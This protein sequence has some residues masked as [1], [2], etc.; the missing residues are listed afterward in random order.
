M[1]LPQVKPITLELLQII[2]QTENDELANVMQKIVFTYSE[3]IA[4]IA[5]EICQHLA[6]TFSM[7]LDTD[8]G[9]DEKAIAAMGLL[10]T[11]ETLISVMDEHPQILA[12]L[13]P[14]VLQVIGHIFTNCI[15]EYYEEALSLVYDLTTKHISPDLWKVFE[16]MYQVFEKDGFDYFTDMMPALHNYVTIDTPAFL[17]NQNHVIAMFNMCK[18]V[19]T[20]DSGE[21]PECHAAKLLEVIIL[22]C[23][24]QIDACIPSF[25]ELVLQRLTKEVKT[26]ELRAMCLQVVIA[27]LYYNPALWLETMDKIQLAAAPTDSISTHFIKQWLHDA[28]CFLG[29]HDRK[30]CVLGFSTLIAMGPNRPPGANECA[31]QIIPV[32]I[33]VFEGLK[34]AYAAK[35]CDH[36]EDESDEEGSE[37]EEAVLSTDDDEIDETTG[38]LEAIKKKVDKGKNSMDSPFPI[39]A[40]MQEAEDD[41]D[42]DDDDDDYD[43][44]DD[45][46]LEA[47]TTPLDE[48]ICEIDEYVVFKQVL[49]GLEASDPIWYTALTGNLTPEQ[50]NQLREVMVLADQRKAAAESKKI[51]Q[52]GGYNFVNQTVPTTF[53]FGG[54][55]LGR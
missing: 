6:T 55:P 9:T 10:N 46:S 25:I 13:E 39:N 23:K 38:Y 34:R 47:Y 3:Q 41:D 20:T 26:S 18:V 33:L 44:A 28:D 40:E 2:R 29:L 14:T 24:G 49:Q 45:C 19:M 54:K 11:I 12:Q 37:D 22:Q 53:N 32:L 17:S 27:A 30:L 43:G 48:E 52:S 35:A 36:N 4:P 15:M 8:E 7:V 16:L 31:Q 1:L 21:D 50:Q 5:V 51:E 42:N